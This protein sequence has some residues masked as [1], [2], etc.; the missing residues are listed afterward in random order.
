NWLLPDTLLGILLNAVGAAL[1][2][3][4]V[5][6]VVSHLRLRPRLDAEAEAGKRRSVVRSWAHPR[7]N[8]IVLGAF[9]ALAGL[10][11]T[12][13]DAREQL[14]ATAG[15]VLVIVTL[16][17]LTRSRRRNQQTAAPETV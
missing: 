3:V 5:L 7:L 16:H 13:T 8:W 4:W 1:L 12:D 10:M 9:A 17:L 6:I 11:L 2:V 15:L 14:I